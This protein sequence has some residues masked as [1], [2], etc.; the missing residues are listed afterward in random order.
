LLTEVPPFSDTEK[1][2][3][4]GWGAKKGDAEWNDEKAG[5]AIAKADE[6]EAQTPAEGAEPE[7]PIDKSKSY[8]DYLAEQAATKRTELGVQE[9]RAPAAIVKDKKWDAAK[10]L[11][12]AEEEDNYIKP[13]EE[14]GRRERQRKE[15]NILDVDMRFVEQPRTRGTGAPRGSG[16]R[17]GGRG[18]GGDRPDRGDRGDRGDRTE[19]ADRGGRGENTRGGRAGGSGPTVTVD[20]KNFP[21]LGSK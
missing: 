19:R 8:A 20:E 17:G 13:Q 18:R 12:R 2:V 6:N 4:Q 21:S 7:E 16:G 11:R 3:G 9:A 1:Q 5:E 10:E 15:K 14:K